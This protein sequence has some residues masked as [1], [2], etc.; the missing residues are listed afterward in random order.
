M[1]RRVDTTM[2]VDKDKFKSGLLMK[3]NYFSHPVTKEV[4]KA[5]VDIYRHN[6]DL[7]APEGKKVMEYWKSKI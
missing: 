5:E 1:A 7:E 6:P 2:V 4:V 3:L